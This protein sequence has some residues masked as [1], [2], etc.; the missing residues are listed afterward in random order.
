MVDYNRVQPGPPASL[1]NSRQS[2]PR[3][4]TLAAIRTGMYEPVSILYSQ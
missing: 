3:F 1:G 4:A 2:D